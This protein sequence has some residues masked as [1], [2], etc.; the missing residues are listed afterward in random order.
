MSDSAPYSALSTQHSL[1]HALEYGAWLLGVGGGLPGLL[2][3]HPQLAA[4]EGSLVH[5]DRAGLNL[6]RDVAARQDLQ[7]ITADDLAVEVAGHHHRR[8][9]H[10]RV[11]LG[12]GRDVE[13]ALGRDLAVEGPLDPYVGRGAQGA[14]PGGVRRDRRDG[15]S[16]RRGRYG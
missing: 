1:P 14:T 8:R 6:A 15:R 4:D 9:A 16:G 5:H 11:D 2:A 10:R 3:L 7:A 12:V 13:L